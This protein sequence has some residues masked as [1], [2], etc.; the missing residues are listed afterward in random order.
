MRPFVSKA[1]APAPPP[2]MTSAE[3]AITNTLTKYFNEKQPKNKNIQNFQLAHFEDFNKA[4]Y[5][6]MVVL[7]IEQL[8]QQIES[9]QNFNKLASLT[10]QVNRTQNA[11]LKEKLRQKKIELFTKNLSRNLTTIQNLNA[12]EANLKRRYIPGNMASLSN[13][14]NKRMENIQ[15]KRTLNKTNLTNANV[16]FLKGLGNNQS[17]N[18]VKQYILKKNILTNADKDFLKSF[19]NNKNAL[20]KLGAEPKNKY[21]NLKKRL[22][23]LSPNANTLRIL[24]SIA[25][26]LTGTNNTSAAMRKLVSNKKNALRSATLTKNKLTNKEVAFLT[27][28]GPNNANARS[29]L[30]A[31]SIIGRVLQANAN[32]ANDAAKKAATNA[33][34]AAEAAKAAAEA[35]KAAVKNNAAANANTATN[36][37][38]KAAN[39]KAA[40]AAAKKAANDA[41][42]KAATNAKAAAEAAK[43]A[44]KNNAAAKTRRNGL[45]QETLKGTG[46]TVNNGT[47]RPNYI[48]RAN[49]AGLKHIIGRIDARQ[50]KDKTLNTNANILRRARQRLNQLEPKKSRGIFGTVLGAGKAIGGAAVYG[51]KA[52]GGVA[53]KGAKVIGPAALGAAA[54]LGQQS[55]K[56][57][58]K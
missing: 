55:T 30:T 52:A 27:S 9:A 6:Y 21:N 40:N 15:R 34:A 51:V 26:S 37:N 43:A 17:R 49:V 57:G 33:K 45:V 22:N 10:N 41:A 24:N 19:G 31:A 29:K 54:Y 16:N 44:V 58:S 14:Y 39:A 11:P 13:S 32:E 20:A 47:G 4:I 18:R 23:A 28:L 35:A 50:K 53:V 3:K 56:R 48:S 2:M 36:A 5:D 25:K 7:R 12:Y 38:A 1:P 42:K 8:A 46:A